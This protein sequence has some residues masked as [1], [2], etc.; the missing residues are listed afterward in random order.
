VT[1]ARPRWLLAAAALLSACLSAPG[2]VFTPAPTLTPA[3]TPTPTA[4]PTP[5]PP[6]ATPAPPPADRFAGWVV[7]AYPGQSQAEMEGILQRLKGAGANVVWI[8]HNNPGEVV[9]GKAEPGLSYAVYAAAQDAESPDQATAQAIVA[10]QHRM[11]RAARAVGLP[12][13]FPIGY[14]VQMGRAWNDRHPAQLRHDAAGQWLNVYNGGVSASPYA[15][16]YRA[17][18]QAYYAWVNDE[19]VRPYRDVL[20]M[21]NLAD[22]PLGGDYSAP[23]EAEFLARHGL[24]FGLAAPERLGAFQNRVIVDYAIW[25]AEQWQAL[26]PDLPVTMSFCGAQGRWSYQMPDVEAL[27]RDTPPNFT[28]TFDAYLHDDPPSE[29]LT[30][31]AVGALVLFTRTLGDSSA[32]YERDFWLWS[33]GNRWGLAGF[34]QRPGGAAEAVANGYLLALA[35]RSTGGRLR[36]LAV[37]AYNVKDQG[38]Y[39]DADPAPYPREAL[40]AQVSAAFADWRRMMVAPGGAAEALVLLSDLAVHGHLGRTRAAVRDSAFNFGRLLPLARADAPAAVVR[41]L[42]T[43]LPESVSRLIVLD[44]SPATLAAADLDGLRALVER[45]GQ[46]LAAPAILSAAWPD[47]HPPR[48]IPLPGEPGA[49]TERDW[50][51]A[52]AAAGLGEIGPGLRVSS[53]ALAVWYQPGDETIPLPAGWRVFNRDGAPRPGALELGPQEVA[54]RP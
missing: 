21:L 20:L 36:G 1:A 31:E 28:P 6:T 3:A 26:A 30:V 9:D 50:A 2:P 8:G 35:A 40:F 32:R 43:P 29:P 47:A 16:E 18:I 33:A 7:F 17:D 23:A 10:A 39:G 25:S 38:L 49:L 22:E 34:S 24:S 12:A 42:P 46:V 48:T 44:A 5:P 13:V 11:L 27:F 37:W 53:G 19:F 54:L 41:A 51:A 15:P 4:S 14:Q 52:L 45:G